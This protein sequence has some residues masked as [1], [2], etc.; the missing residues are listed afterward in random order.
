ME[1]GQGLPSVDGH[2]ALI[3]VELDCPE[4]LACIVDLSA[5]ISQFVILELRARNMTRSAT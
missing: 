3:V 1:S 4:E 5:G 2:S